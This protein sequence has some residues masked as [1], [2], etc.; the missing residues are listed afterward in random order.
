MTETETIIPSPERIPQRSEMIALH[1]RMAIS[2]EALNPEK[3][4][5]EE[6]KKENL[7]NLDQTITAAANGSTRERDEYWKRRWQEMTAS[8]SSL[9]SLDEKQKLEKQKEVWR[10]LMI[11]RFKAE[12]NQSLVK[13]LRARGI[14]GGISFEEFTQETASQIYQRYFEAQSQQQTEVVIIKDAKQEKIVIPSNVNQF[15]DDIILAY[16]GNLEA[17]E[18]DLDAIVWYAGIFGNKMANKVIAEIIRAKL[19]LADETKKQ[20]LIQEANT[21]DRR[22][23]LTPQEKD[24]CQW[25]FEGMKMERK[26]TNASLPSQE[27]LP[28]EIQPQDLEEGG[29]KKE[30]AQKTKA[31]SQLEA[32]DEETS[33]KA[34]E[35]I[36]KKL[37]V[38][39]I[40]PE[41]GKTP[42]QQL[43]EYYQQDNPDVKNSGYHVQTALTL[44]QIGKTFEE[45]YGVKPPSS[46][47]SEEQ[48]EKQI[49]QILAKRLANELIQSYYYQDVIAIIQPEIEQRA[50]NEFREK[51]QDKISP[52]QSLDDVFTANPNLRKDYNSILETTRSL[53]YAEKGEEVFRE[54]ILTQPNNQAIYRKILTMLTEAYGVKPPS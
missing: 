14:I 46:D 25:L 11:E 5:E 23:N 43:Y 39:G 45:K 32:A 27:E 31:E 20:Q 17:I 40:S 16:Q 4:L 42:A 50:E 7:G 10:S 15:I 37:E 29:G 51:H 53:V 22:N 38:L 1:T 49:R 13:K 8:D 24:Y 6:I 41:E 52:D 30:G 19:I 21:N 2:G 9:T 33:Q 34:I 47:L 26:K 18:Q 54:R 35:I 12:R 36:R 28:Q 44:S 3:K 48:R